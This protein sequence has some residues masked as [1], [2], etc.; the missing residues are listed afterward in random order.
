MNNRTK[1]HN[2]ERWVAKELR[3]VFPHIATSRAISKERD[4]MKVDMMNSNE[5]FNGVLP[6]SIQ[7]KST[8]K[9]VNYAELFAEIAALPN[10]DK[11]IIHQLTQK[12][13]TRNKVVGVFVI[14]EFTTY[15]KL[16]KSYYERL[17]SINTSN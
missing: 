17:S 16:T 6:H 14:M 1:G 4:D 9:C 8:V 10:T 2:F 11:I 5:I 7:C 13:N 15:K 3:E 12:Q